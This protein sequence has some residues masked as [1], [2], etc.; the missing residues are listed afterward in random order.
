LRAC[1]DGAPLDAHDFEGDALAAHAAHREALAARQELAAAGE[2]QLPPPPSPPPSLTPAE[3]AR[4]TAYRLRAARERYAR[5][6]AGAAL[7]APADVAAWHALYADTDAFTQRWLSLASAAVAD[8]AESGVTNV[9]VTAGCLLPTLAKLLLF[10]LNHLFPHNTVLSARREGKAACFARLAARYGARAR[11][12]AVGDGAE[13]AAAAR[14]MRWPMVPVALLAEDGAM[15]PHAITTELL[16][17]R[18]ADCAPGVDEL[19]LPSSSAGRG[20]AAVTER[21]SAAAA[22]EEQGTQ[23]STEEEAH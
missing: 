21:D 15:P 16:R 8:A 14:A 5:G 23:V 3:R 18:L 12:V 10:K 7:T 19:T 13:E 11:F 1:D 9:L 2:L 20:V 6:V 17:T 22:G 4:L